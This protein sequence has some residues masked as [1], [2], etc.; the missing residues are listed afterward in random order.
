MNSLGDRPNWFS[1][2]ANLSLALGL[3]QASLVRVL[4][5]TPP[6]GAGLGRAWRCCIYVLLHDNSH[7]RLHP[8]GCICCSKNGQVLLPRQ[9]HSTEDD[10][11]LCACSHCAIVPILP[12]DSGLS[13]LAATFWRRSGSPRGSASHKARLP[14]F[15]SLTIS[16][17]LIFHYYLYS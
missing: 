7:P 2:L 10:C 9:S 3:E 16:P 4:Q 14:M 13:V 15:F 11:V 12:L 1:A 5:G 6:F 17:D 8:L